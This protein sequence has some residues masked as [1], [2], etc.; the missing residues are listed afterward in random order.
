MALLAELRRAVTLDERTHAAIAAEAGINPKGFSAFMNGRRGL[1]VETV[2]ELARALR[3]DLKLVPE[4]AGSPTSAAVGDATV[5]PTS[6]HVAALLRLQFGEMSI[7]ER[8]KVKDALELILVLSRRNPSS[9]APLLY[10]CI[11][12]A[13]AR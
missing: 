7:A 2:E 3:L 5:R 11:Q 13:E 12:L 6:K 10:Q 1:A 4:Q 9:I 8:A